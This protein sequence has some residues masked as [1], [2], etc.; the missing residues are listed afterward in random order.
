MTNSQTPPPID[1]NKKSCGNIILI[2]ISSIWTILFGGIDLFSGWLNEQMIVE[3]ATAADTRWINHIIY[4][5]LILIVCGLIAL[6]A[7]NPQTKKIFKLWSLAAIMSVLSTPLRF[8]YLTAQKETIILQIWIMLVVITVTFLLRK[9]NKPSEDSVD[10]G[11]PGISGAIILLCCTMCLP[12]VMWGALGSVLDTVLA[13]LLGGT[14]AWYAVKVVS[15]F[16]LKDKIDDG[17]R[18]I[19]AVVFDGF[20]IAVFL[21]ISV[22]ALAVNGSEQLLVMTIPITGWLVALFFHLW[23]KSRKRAKRLSG[24]LFGLAAALPLAFYD[25]DELSELIAGGSGEALE[26][27]VKAAVTTLIGLL[28]LTILAVSSYKIIRKVKMP[29]FANFLLAAIGVMGVVTAYLGWGQVGFFGDHQFIILK[30]QADLSQENEISGY[31]DRREGVY[32]DLVDT[33][34]KSQV[35]LR[36]RL[37][38]LNISYTPYYL[39][40]AIEVDG[41]EIVKLLLQNEPSVDRILDNPNLRPLPDKPVLDEADVPSLTGEPFWNLSMIEADRV[42]DELGIDGS[43]II[44]GQTDSGVDGRQPELAA[45]YRGAETEDDY[46][47]FDPWY[48]TIFPTDAG[49]HG[50]MTL[51][52]ALGENTG[53]APGAEWI[54]CVNL[55]RNL[56]NPA[57]YLDCMQFML[58]PFPQNGDP[59]T[60]GDPSKGAMVVNNSWGC[61]EI[62]GC[63]A[64]VFQSAVEAMKTAGIFMSVAAGNSGYY[65]CGTVSDPLSIYADVLT[66]GSVN[67]YGDLS[68]FS[69]I[70]PVNVDGSGR[71]KPD[72]LAPGEDVL[73]AYP[74]G[75]YS[76]AS[77]TS[78]S[79]P[80][81]TG[82]VALMWSANPAL[83]GNIDA[84]TEILKSTVKAYNGSEPI[85]GDINDAVGFGIL[86]AYQAVKAA[87]EFSDNSE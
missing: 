57:L 23:D 42:V 61:P 9:K 41:G 44:I 28:F 53:V 32:S 36:E 54:G 62:E 80:H 64:T 46:N 26:W 49:G 47:W 51:S 15:D 84:T 24:L 55:A 40:N 50:T 73:T 22:S 85:C 18:R 87:L 70:G 4:S 81:V 58:A 30:K 66:S 3:S 76:T 69:S 17:K 5:G 79:A 16:Y 68:Y 2:I 10:S 83:I 78:F 82:V 21:L 43:G 77:G 25:M 48:G 14:F 19:A 60:D 39:V 7:K 86:D 27:A 12:W 71:S 72:L 34:E 8:L 75:G 45:A 74:G 13:V 63:D 67:Q 31:F 20:V 11:K 6:F 56:G 65:G 1:K 33:A 35:N 59:F 38:R 37:D 52:V 29:D